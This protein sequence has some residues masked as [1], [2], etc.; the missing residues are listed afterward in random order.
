MVLQRS[1]YDEPNISKVLCS[2]RESEHC[3]LTWKAVNHHTATCSLPFP[4]WDGG[5]NRKKKR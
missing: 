5:K 4:Q 1:K 2:V 3:G